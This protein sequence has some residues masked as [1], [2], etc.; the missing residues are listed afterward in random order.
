MV[1]I[2][3]LTKRAFFNPI[4]PDWYINNVLLEDQLLMDALQK[5]GMLVARNYWDNTELQF[6]QTKAI[7][8]RAIWDYFDRYQ[9]FAPWLAS[10]DNKCQLI[11]PIDTIQW[12]IHKGYLKILESKGINIP[13]TIFIDPGQ[14]KSLQD[15]CAISGWNRF[16][17][18]PAIAGGGRHT[19]C[20][21]ISDAHLHEPLFNQLK[22]SETWLLQE[23]Q[24]QITSKGEA[25]H[26]LFG[27]NYSHSVLKRA[28]RG[29][30]RV[31]DDYG[32]TVHN[33]TATSEEIGF[34]EKVIAE[35]TPTPVYARVDV[36]WDNRDQLC[37]A[38][39]ELIEP[40][41]W[42]RNSSTAAQMMA[43]AIAAQMKTSA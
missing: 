17:L 30:F 4:N 11:N 20:F 32:G 43:K 40:E 29:D 7:V 24:H 16:V 3:L 10:V 26:V 23:Y 2:T 28:K 35:V 25:T 1:D 36:M 38:E 41:L 42:L 19:H 15:W 5:E 22:G 34:A 8:F 27:G 18:K 9:E 39:L 31:Q 14:S 37:L 21:T 33:Y 12:N 13:P 6:D